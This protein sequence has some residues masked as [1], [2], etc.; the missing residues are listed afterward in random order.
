MEEGVVPQ[1]WKSANVTPIYKKGSKGVPGNYRPVSLTC[2]LCKVMES[3]IRD[4]VVEHLTEKGLIRLSQHGFMRGRS[5]VTN[6]LEFLEELTR[7]V[8]KGV[9][10]DVLYLDFS[11]AFDKV[12]IRRLLAKCAGL[13]IRGKLLAWIEEWLT[14]RR[15]RVVLNGME[16]EWGDIKSGVVQGSVLGPVLFLMFIND[17]DEAIEG[18]GGIIKKFA[19]DTKWLK[20]VMG[21]EDRVAF[22]QGIDSLF[23]WSDKWQMPFNE[24]KCHVLHVGRT[25]AK[26]QYTMGGIQLEGVGQEKDVGVI[27]SDNLRPSLQ[28]AKAAKKANAVLGQLSRGVTYRDK[29]CFMSLYQTYVRPHLEYAVAAWSPWTLGDKEVLE[30]VQRRAVRMVTNLTGKTYQAR[31]SELGMTTLEQRRERGDLIQAYKVITGKEVVDHKTWFSRCSDREEG[32]DTRSTT[33]LYNVERMEGRLEIRKN[34]WSI[35]VADKSAA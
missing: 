12:P 24:D 6:L 18:V 3:V 35:R 8:D 17:I 19:D 29:E 26:H 5:T 20:R 21:E 14:G 34:F 33:G 1:E 32:R 23:R 25:N 31:L 4:A 30:A 16:S 7:G 2:I 15:Q 10:M 22:Q 28:C 9:D 27:I 11:K 13:G